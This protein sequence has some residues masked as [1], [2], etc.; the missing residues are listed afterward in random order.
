MT[1][2]RG[3]QATYDQMMAELQLDSDGEEREAKPHEPWQDRR[4]YD[5]LESR[6]RVTLSSPRPQEKVACNATDSSQHI[7]TTNSALSTSAPVINAN[8]EIFGA[9]SAAVKD[10]GFSGGTR[11]A[12][13]DALRS[14]VLRSPAQGS[15]AIR[16]YV[17][18]DR[19]GLNRLHPV[20]RLF[21]ESGK[22]FLLC[23]QKR[24][25]SKTSNYLLTMEQNPTNRRSNL[26]VGKLRS[27]WS[28][29]EYTMYD[30]GMSPD[31]TAL[32][33]NVR[34]ILGAVEFSYDDMGP[35]R[36]AA[37][38][39]HLQGNGIA[40]TWKDKPADAVSAESEKLLM[41][42]NKRPHFDEKTGGHVLD[43]GGRVTM[44]SI[45]NF[46]MMCDALGDETVLQ[47]GRVSCQP[48]GPRRQC[49]CHKST[50]VM[51]VKAL[52][53]YPLNP[54]QGFAICLATLDT[55]FTDLKLYDN[56]TKLIK[57]K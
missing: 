42:H 48:P 23:A 3:Q 19:K 21:L 29:S 8:R 13:I 10:A 5:G 4:K 54:L 43:F 55:K 2:Q 17:E 41:L 1:R 25:S 37:Q 39:P 30:D 45:K 36:L 46:Q 15:A 24:A 11:R 32:E 44:P 7:T 35:G 6:R 14:F 22:Q 38:I 34:N 33:A 28:G 47:F 27:N 51:D 9:A 20:F 50:F 26:I 31:K 40:S 52:L 49:K 18:R 16:C 57:R 53:Q 12:E 56:V